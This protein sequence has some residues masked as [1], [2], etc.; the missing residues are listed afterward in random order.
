VVE[1]TETAC[2]SYTWNGNTYTESGDYTVT[3]QTEQGRDSIEILH[4]TINQSVTTEENIV[5]CDS[6]EWN[7]VVY[8]E[9]GDYVFNTTT[10][11]GCDS[12]VT[13][14]LTILPEALVENEELVL[15]PSELPYEWYG[16][17]L[18]K[19][20]SYTATEQYTGMECDSV[21]HE[22]TLNV[23]VQTLPASVTLPTVRAGEAIN[24]EAPTAEIN[25][26]IAADSW[27]AP[28]AVV[29]WYIQSN[30]TW[31]ELT[32]EPVKAGIS[33]IVLKYAV[34]SD[35]GSIES[36]VM[37]ISVTTTAL[38]DIHSITTDTYKII[39]DNHLLIIHDGKTFDI[40]G[41]QL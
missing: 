25:A 20:G 15:C 16:Q 18:T 14:H 8:S 4:L 1:Y 6:Y 35:C 28:N 26:H 29:A 38:D 19:A 9:S 24:V 37:N 7:G 17:S 13:L 10:I 34:N 40:M 41:Q 5:T 11:S 22:L 31:S 30:D 3:L 12:V 39:R 36:E 23:Y 32:E 21:I 2:D 27:Y 33:N